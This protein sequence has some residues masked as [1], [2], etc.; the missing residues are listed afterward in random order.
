MGFTAD[1][2]GL[3]FPVLT[4]KNRRSERLRAACPKER[5]ERP[6]YPPKGRRPLVLK[7]KRR[8]HN[9]LE[10]FEVQRLE[11]RILSSHSIA[12]GYT[13]CKRRGTYAHA[14][15]FSLAAD[16]AIPVGPHHALC[17]YPPILG[18]THT[19]TNKTTGP[20]DCRKPRIAE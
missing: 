6:F 16:K 14:G 11:R 13:A 15:P 1:Q 20:A 17:F 2:D 5:S 4:G 3:S 19:K 7:A 18:G 10:A 12:A 9:T 8:R